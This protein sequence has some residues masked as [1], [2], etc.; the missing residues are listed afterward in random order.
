MGSAHRILPYFQQ[1]NHQNF[2]SFLYLFDF[3]V[4]VALPK[5]YLL[6]L[7]FY[8]LMMLRSKLYISCAL[9]L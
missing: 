9:Y 7:L 6:Q 8:N 1:L 5:I 3:H 4:S 2:G